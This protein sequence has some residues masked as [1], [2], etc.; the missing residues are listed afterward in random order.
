MKSLQQLVTQMWEHSQWPSSHEA[1]ISSTSVR[2]I[3]HRPKQENG[4]G[5]YFRIGIFLATGN[6]INFLLYLRPRLKVEDRVR[7][8]ARLL[9]E[10]D[11]IDGHVAEI[12]LSERGL[13][14][15]FEFPAKIRCTQ[16]RPPP[17]VPIITLL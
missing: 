14:D 6:L 12:T 16:L 7:I 10:I 5:P 13:E 9:G 3:S 8:L 4:A 1:S 17:P 2:F 15:E 11:V